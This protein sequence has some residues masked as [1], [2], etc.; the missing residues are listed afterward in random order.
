MITDPAMTLDRTNKKAPRILC[1]G[2]HPFPKSMPPVGSYFDAKLLFRMVGGNLGNCIIGEYARKTICGQFADI[3]HFPG[4][5]PFSSEEANERF[6]H[7]LIVAANWFTCNWLSDFTK[8]INWFRNLRIPVTVVGLGQQLPNDAI[9]RDDRIRFAK[10]VPESF[11]RLLRVWLDHG[12][13]IAVRGEITRELLAHVGINAVVTTGCPTWFVNGHNQPDIINK[14]PL[15]SNARIAIH[16]TLRTA[17]ELFRLSSSHP[18]AVYVIQ[19]EIPFVPFSGRRPPSGWRLPL[20]LRHASGLKP[21]L[22][23]GRDPM[24]VH[25]SQLSDWEVFLRSCAFSFG[26]R[27]HGTICAIKNGIPA[28]IV[29]HD[30]RIA[31]FVDLFRIPSVSSSDLQRS[32]FSLSSAYDHADFSDMNRAYPSLLDQ[33]QTFLRSHGLSPAFRT[34]RQDT[35]SEIDYPAFRPFATTVFEW[36]WEMGLVR[37]RIRKRLWR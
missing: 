35:K 7:I 33:Y 29:R 24:F 16:G 10:S 18:N 4:H 17:G 22:M 37:K 3:T 25:F 26:R 13:S 20:F 8:E 30:Q 14:G 31:E 6:D 27:I 11:V 23:S 9:S 5:F 34:I 21:A 28:V 2:A 32:G 15:D 1:F 12:P 36:K 19:S